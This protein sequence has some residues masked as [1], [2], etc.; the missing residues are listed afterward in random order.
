MRRRSASRR[1][2]NRGTWTPLVVLMLILSLW[3][4]NKKTGKVE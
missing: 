2:A 3:S 4:A 1:G